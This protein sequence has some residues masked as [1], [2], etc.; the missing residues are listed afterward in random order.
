MRDTG[1]LEH[2]RVDAI[3]QHESAAASAESPRTELP[4][5]ARTCCRS[6]DGTATI[7][8]CSRTRTGDST[9]P[10]ADLA[11]QQPATVGD[12]LWPDAGLHRPAG[13]GGGCAGRWRVGKVTLVR[14]A[15]PGSS[16]NAGQARQ[17]RDWIRS[18]VNR[19]LAR[20]EA[21][22]GGRLPSPVE[23]SGAPILRTSG[24]SGWTASAVS[25]RGLRL[26][27]PGM[28]LHIARYQVRRDGSAPRQHLDGLGVKAG[29]YGSG[30]VPAG[31]R[32]E[33]C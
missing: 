5:P 33:R 29:G 32:R 22:F 19:T 20:I 31:W 18:A 30:A 16:P 9:T 2:A 28:V 10:P 21:L 4:S 26:A 12:Q 1:C 24:Q 23:Q 13:Q 7:I 6:S 15:G 17:V 3:P 27:R 14:P 25:R 8:K 11:H